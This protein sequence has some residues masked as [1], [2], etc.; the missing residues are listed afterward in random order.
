M[1]VRY[2]TVP[3]VPTPGSSARLVSGCKQGQPVAATGKRRGG[4]REPPLFLAN[5]H[6]LCSC[7]GFT[8]NFA[9][10]VPVTV[11]SKLSGSLGA[12]CTLMIMAPAV[13]TVT[14][15]VTYPALGLLRTSV[16]SVT[17]AS[18]LLLG[19]SR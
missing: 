11:W 16:V 18:C 13:P 1:K 17:R 10:L 3:D 5:Y 6:A 12:D 8:L 9:V 4:S 15:N 14:R 7:Y 19:E 2:R